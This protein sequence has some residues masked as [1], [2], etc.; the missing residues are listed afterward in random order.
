[1]SGSKPF[2]Q[3]FHKNPS[4]SLSDKLA[5]YSSNYKIK[6]LLKRNRTIR[7]FNALSTTQMFREI[8]KTLAKTSL[9]AGMIVVSYCNVVLGGFGSFL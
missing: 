4:T 3:A 9:M 1:M 8:V 6:Q 5:D 7:R 2:S